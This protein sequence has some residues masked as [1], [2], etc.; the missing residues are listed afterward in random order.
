VSRYAPE[1]FLVF[2]CSRGLEVV[3]PSIDGLRRCHAFQGPSWTQGLPVHTWSTDTV[4]RILGSSC[5]QVVK[6]PQT[7]AYEDLREYF[8][9][10]WCIH[11]MFIPQ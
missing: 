4:E 6:A 11:P 8:I 7:V 5:A 1:D 3:A 2:H 10:A 9:T